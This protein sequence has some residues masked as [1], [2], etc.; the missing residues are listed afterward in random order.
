MRRVEFEILAMERLGSSRG[1]TETAAVFCIF[2][3]PA[4]HRPPSGS[5]QKE[6]IIWVLGWIFETT[7]QLGDTPGMQVD[8][9]NH[10]SFSCV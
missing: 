6:L 8:C 7:V 2:I 5:Q 9:N 1:H 3:R 10:S 4:P